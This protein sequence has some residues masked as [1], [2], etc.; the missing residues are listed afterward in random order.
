MFVPKWGRY[1]FAAIVHDWL[2][3]SGS[4]TKNEADGI[5]REIMEEDGVKG[6]RL[7]SIRKAS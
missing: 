7:Y 2:Y 3:T 6:W 1:G 4:G 5:M